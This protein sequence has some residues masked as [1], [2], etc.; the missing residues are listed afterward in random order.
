MII[1]SLDS[2]KISRSYIFSQKIVLK[3]YQTWSQ[4]SWYNKNE[5]S[6]FI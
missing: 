3:V 5:E 4:T 6:Q 1:Y 2:F